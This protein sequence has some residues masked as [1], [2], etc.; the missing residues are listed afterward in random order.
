MLIGR[1]QGTI[2]HESIVPIQVY[3]Y[4]IDKSN[5]SKQ[6]AVADKM[7]RFYSDYFGR[8]PYR[9]LNLALRPAEEPGGHAPAGIVITNRVYSYMK[10]RFGRDPLYIPA[11]PDF[12]LA[13]EIAHQWWGQAVGWRGY[14][15]QWL[16][17]GFAQFAAAEYI[18]SVEGDK[19]WLKLSEEFRDWI[20]EKSSAGPIIL[21]TRLGH[22]TQDPRAFSAL[23]YNKGAYV[24]NMLKQW[25]GPEDFQKCLAEFY[26]LYQFKRVGIEEFTEVAQRYSAEDLTP[27]FDQWLKGWTIPNVDWS[28]RSDASPDGNLLKV[29]F[30][31]RAEDFYHLKIPVEA[32]DERGQTF[33]VLAL[34]NSA[35]QEIEIP[36]PFA[37]ATVTIDPLHENLAEY[38]LVK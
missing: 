25:L 24:L 28:W 19:A 23:M 15:D 31:Q 12:L 32:K 36:V 5:A 37:P 21:G 26:N 10:V 35:T 3:F 7:L 11:F 27:F 8:Y 6:A 9:N 14:R 1:L 20:E 16:S 13:H 33:R 30:V 29:K 38:R 4:N 2:T 17:E 22:L 18:R 34:V